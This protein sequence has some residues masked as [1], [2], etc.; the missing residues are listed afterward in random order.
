MADN[1]NTKIDIAEILAI[2]EAVLK[3]SGS[4]PHGIT[5]EGFYPKPFARLLSE[6]LALARALLGPD[7]DLTSGSAIRKLLEL[8]AL[9]DARTWAAAATMFDDIFIVSAVG[10]AL[11][12]HGEEL[13]FPRPYLEAHGKLNLRL[14]GTLPAGTSLTIPRGARLLTPGGHH[15]ATDETVVLSASSPLRETAVM[16]FYP[17]AGHNLNP[18]VPAQKLDRWNFA[19]PLL[20]PLALAEAAAGA[21]LVAIEHTAALTGGELQW[22][23]DRYRQLL[24]NVPRS[25][26]TV[27]AIRLAVSLIPGVRQVQVRDGIGGLDIYQ[28]IFGNFNFI[29]RVFGSERDL[30]T[31]YYFTVLVAPTPAAIWEGPDGLRLAIESAI[32]DLRPISIF[33]RVEQAE[34]VAIGIRCELVVRGLPLPSGP[35]ASVNASEPARALKARLL[36]RVRSYVDGLQFGEPVRHAEVTWALMNEPGVADVRNLQLLRYP[37]GFDTID[38]SVA[39]GAP[40]PEQLECCDNVELQA[41]QIPVLVEDDAGLAIL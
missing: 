1:T 33:P 6:K 36:R 37:P 24:L 13:G 38:F 26:W 17:G 34:E 30:G 28:S 2:D 39:P 15:A 5:R 35:A 29:E 7:V 8:S 40:H 14:V 4:T 18:A 23:D 19:D 9:E 21:P 11:T 16:A 27:E 31:P 20:G 10:D 32:E 22:P 25:I 3:T 12:R 41:N